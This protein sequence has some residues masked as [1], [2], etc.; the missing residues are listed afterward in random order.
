[1]TSFRGFEN[2]RTILVR[3]QNETARHRKK[4]RRPPIKKV[5]LGKKAIEENYSVKLRQGKLI[6]SFR[7]VNITNKINVILICLTYL[8]IIKII[9]IF[10]LFVVTK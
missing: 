10:T 9:L 7:I 8:N 2:K 4:K 6:F 3:I 1:M 5:F